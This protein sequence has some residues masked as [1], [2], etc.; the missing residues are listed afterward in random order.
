MCLKDLCF[1]VS[2]PPC[3]RQRPPDSMPFTYHVIFFHPQPALR[4]DPARLQYERLMC[5]SLW[6][7]SAQSPQKKEA[8]F[9]INLSLIANLTD[10]LLSVQVTD[11]WGWKCPRNAAWPHFFH[12]KHTHMDI[13]TDI[14]AATQTWRKYLTSL[15]GISF[16]LCIFKS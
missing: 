4:A 13:N 8:D 16:I 14:P 9:Y 15:L 6:R 10:K 1:P 11:T 5:E 3:V 12:V 2:H 7:W